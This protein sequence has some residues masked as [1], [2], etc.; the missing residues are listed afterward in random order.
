MVLIFKSYFK[1]HQEKT[2]LLTGHEKYTLFLALASK[3][4]FDLDTKDL[5]LACNISTHES[6]L[7][8]VL[9]KIKLKSVSYRVHSSSCS[10][11]HG[12]WWHWAAPAKGRLLSALVHKWDLLAGSEGSHLSSVMLIPVKH[13]G[14]MQ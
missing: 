3:Y 13:H 11:C 5:G 1:I 2:K 9:E 6:D 8:M 7:F 14:L 12:G 10:V 4:D